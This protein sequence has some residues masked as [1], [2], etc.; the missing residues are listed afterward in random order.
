LG[1]AGRGEERSA[2]D[3]PGDRKTSA[4]KSSGGGDGGLSAFKSSGGGDT[5]S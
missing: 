3:G 4:F 2:R 1:C 5:G